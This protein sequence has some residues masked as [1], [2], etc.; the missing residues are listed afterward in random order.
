MAEQRVTAAAVPSSGC[1]TGHFQ[2]ADVPPPGYRMQYG[3]ARAG[4]LAYW[5]EDSEWRAVR[6]G[7][8]IVG[9]Y[10]KDLWFMG[11]LA[12]ATRCPS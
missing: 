12:L 8:N 2:Y 9:A 1:G 11:I 7:Q 5:N 3:P 6:H 10:T 4:D